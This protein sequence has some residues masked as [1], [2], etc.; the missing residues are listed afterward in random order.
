LQAVPEHYMSN[1][2]FVQLDGQPAVGRMKGFPALLSKYHNVE[3]LLM[4]SCGLKSVSIP[5]NF[6]GPLLG[7]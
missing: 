1:V 6:N 4:R 5:S 7:E 3:V 2:A